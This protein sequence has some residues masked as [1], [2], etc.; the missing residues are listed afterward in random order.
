MLLG[1]LLPHFGQFASRRTILDGARRAEE[2]GFDEVV[3]RDHLLFE[4]H[5]T[6][7]Q[8]DVTFYDALTTLTAVGAVTERIGL[9]T[10]ALI[11]YRHPVLLARMVASMT[12]LVG[13]RL[14]LG[15][16]AGRFGREFELAGIAGPT[17]LPMVESYLASLRALGE[18]DGVE[19]H[20]EFVDLQDVTVRPHP[21]APIP[22]WYCGSTPASARFAV[23]HCDGWMAGRITLATVRSRVEL[24]RARAAVGG[25]NA[26]LVGVIPPTS[27]AATR[28][29][30][31]AGVNLAGLLEWANTMGRWWVKPASGR[32]E[33][34][35]DLEGSLI[36]GDPETVI[37]QTLAFAASGVDRIVFD[38]RSGFDRWHESLELL[39]TEV[40]PHVRARLA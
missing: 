40:L 28:A 12:R 17:G 21:A 13:D 18:R 7:E 8:S 6:M 5:G 29:E 33:T 10:G 2:L 24:M 35:D 26:P 27:I 30:A 23:D 37:E 36:A 39:G 14:T 22:L 32:F 19:Q 3:V 38:M 11:P 20:D 25:R 9:G 4:P 31:M 15:I 34:A 16:G 1:V